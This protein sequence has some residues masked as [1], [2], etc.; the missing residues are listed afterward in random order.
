MDAETIKA[1]REE[2]L[3][4]LYARPGSAMPAAAILRAVRKA[5]VECTDATLTTQLQALDTLDLIDPIP[6]PTMPAVKAWQIT[7]G[8][9]THCEEHG[10]T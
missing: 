1:I 8:G 2:I 5:G 6:D 4:Y 7:K 9:L 10:I 3:R